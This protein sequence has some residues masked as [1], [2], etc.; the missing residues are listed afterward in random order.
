MLTIDEAT[1]EERERVLAITIAAYQEYA[2]E[3][4]PDWWAR[5]QTSMRRAIVEDATVVVLV[6]REEGV[7]LGSVLYCPINNIPLVQNDLPELRLLAV[8]PEG[9]N[10]G[11][12][13]KLIDECERRARRSGALTLHT[14]RLMK[15]ARAMYERRG[16]ERY[17]QI[18][19]GPAP[20]FIV[21]GYK[22]N[23]S[24]E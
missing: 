12:G 22:K 10:L 20:G 18:D 7:I 1:G 14:T 19:F 9:R 21:W 5:Y 24:A 11:I 17:P 6:A 8:P 4:G 23:L 2:A 3:G 16:Y 15:T 13:G